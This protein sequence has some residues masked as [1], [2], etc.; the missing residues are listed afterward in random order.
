MGPAGRLA[1][2]EN[3]DLRAGSFALVGMLAAVSGNPIEGECR[4][5]VLSCFKMKNPHY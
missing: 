5:I 3:E 2:K 4:E 1:L